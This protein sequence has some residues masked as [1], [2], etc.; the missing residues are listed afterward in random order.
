MEKQKPVVELEIYFV[1]HGQSK[2][3]INLFNEKDT[4]LEI[5]DPHLSELGILQARKAGKYLSDVDFD[6]CYSSG[7]VRTVQTANEIMKF[8]NKKKTLN[9]LPLITEVA[10]PDDFD[11]R[12]MN[13]LREACETAVPADGYCENERLLISN[14][15]E[16]E[17]ALYERA[18]K[19]IEYFRSHHNKGEKILV[20]GHAAFNTIMLFHIMGFEKSPVFDV[21]IRNTAI[22][23]VIF[24]KEGTNKFGDVVFDTVNDT[25]HFMI[26]DEEVAPP[27]ISKLISENPE[28]IDEIASAFALLLKKTHGKKAENC[29]DIKPETV[30]KTDEI[31]HFI[32]VEK[33]QKLRSL[34]TAVEDT[35]TCLVLDPTTNSAFAEKGEAF[36]KD[37][38]GIYMG[39]PVFDLGKIYESLAATSE[40]D[41]KVAYKTLGFCKETAER[42]WD[43]LILKYF[44]GEDDALIMRADDRARLVAYFNIFCRLTKDENCDKAVFTYY[45]EK[46]IEYITKVG[47]LDFE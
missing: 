6:V 41:R 31:M 21:E 19:A 37:D 30:K 45:K 7:L 16:E 9:V 1:R 18:T 26:S 11:G 20:A 36:W 34:V 43:K 10:V 28:E 17:E 29:I 27:T 47:S 23:H 8:Q 24:Y 42:F 32:P 5:N 33:W 13:E 25:S 46:L 2:G 35:G 3:N 4:E 22:A 40:T 38:R 39:Y 14:T 15:R 44:E 12:P